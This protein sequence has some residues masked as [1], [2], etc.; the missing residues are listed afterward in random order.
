MHDQPRISRR[1]RRPGTHGKLHGADQRHDKYKGK[2]KNTQS[3][4][5]VAPVDEQKQDGNNKAAYRDRFVKVVYRELSL[6]P[7]RLGEE[8]TMQNTAHTKRY[9]YGSVHL[10]TPV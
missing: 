4:E 8:H 6:E 10:C 7:C 5:V 1:L 3:L 9:Q 2:K